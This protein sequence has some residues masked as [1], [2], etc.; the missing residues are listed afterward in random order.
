MVKVRKQFRSEILFVFSVGALLRIFYVAFMA[1]WQNS[2]LFVVGFAWPIW[3]TFALL[4]DRN[5]V[6]PYHFDKGE[7][8]IA[9][10]CFAG[11]SWFAYMVLMVYER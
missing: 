7:N 6:G 10:F 1:G 5:M 4:Y 3:I 9:R 8:Q 11:V 2:I